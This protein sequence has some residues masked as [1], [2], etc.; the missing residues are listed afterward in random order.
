[1]S[2]KLSSDNNLAT[3][4]RG[5]HDESDHTVA[6]S[7]DGQSTQQFELERFGLGLGAQTT[8]LNSLGVKFDGTIRKSKSLLHNR[9]QF[10][11]AT[12]VLSQDVLRTGGTDD[13]LGSVGS[14]ADFDTR[15]TIF[16]KLA[17]QQLIQL[18]VEDTVRYELFLAGQS[19]SSSHLEEGKDECTEAVL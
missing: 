6:R 11:N 16:G 15:V 17:S 3:L 19:T 8:V 1:L 10:A 14:G 9:G 13:N 7:S 4:G 2:S 18:G 5:F 12:T